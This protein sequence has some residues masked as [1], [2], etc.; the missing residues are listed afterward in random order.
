MRELGA[1]VAVLLV[2]VSGFAPFAVVGVAS[3]AGNTTIVVA[4]DG[5]GDHQTIQAGV[6]AATAG[7]TVEVQS[8]TYTEQVTVDTEI[9]LVAPNGATLDGTGISGGTV[10]IDVTPSLGSGLT[11]EG[12]TVTGYTDGVT[13]GGSAG[14]S[15]DDASEESISG[16]WTIRDLVSTG[17]AEDGLDI[18]AATGTGWTLRNVRATGNSDD[19]IEI[20]G[21]AS[22]TV[23]WRL[24]ESNASA[25]DGYGIRVSSTS[26]SWELLD[27]TTSDNRDT[28]LYVSGTSGAWTIGHHNASANSF[29]GIDIAGGGGGD[30]TIH[31]TTASDN[32]D[33]TLYR[34]DG[35][36]PSTEFATTTTDDVGYYSFDV[37]APPGEST[38]E[39]RL[40]FDDPTGEYAQAWYR[41]RHRWANA[42]AMRNAVGSH[43]RHNFQTLREAGMLL[44]VWVQ[45][46]S[47]C[48]D[49]TDA[50]SCTFP[51]REDTVT[52]DP[53]E[54]VAV[55][56]E[57]W[58]GDDRVYRDYD[59]DDPATRTTMFGAGREIAPGELR[60]KTETLTAPIVDGTYDYRANSTSDTRNGVVSNSTATYTIEVSGSVAQQARSPDGFSARISNPGS[61]EP[62]LLGGDDGVASTSGTTMQSL[63]LR[64]D[65]SNYTVNVTGNDS[66]PAGTAPLPLAPGG[67]AFGYFTVGHSIPD[68]AI[69]NV[70][71][72]LR[73]DRG[74]LSGAGIQPTDVTVYRYVD[75]VPTP[76]PTAVVEETSTAH[77]YETTSPGLS[78]FAVGTAD[79]MSPPTTEN[80]TPSLDRTTAGRT[81]TSVDTTGASSPGFTVVLTALALLVV[82]VRLSRRR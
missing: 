20:G 34:K 73:V 46:L 3:A 49:P 26:G 43:D 15:Y 40:H 59:V 44:D 78:V 72:R 32:S 38:V 52:V 69:A 21:F 51:D 47:T 11:I 80:A 50:D 79:L 9:T 14:E 22:G 65:G 6:D 82:A 5:T 57:L 76:L 61:G 23:A 81:G 62:V 4:A 10:G 27:S 60:S 18:G 35:P 74:D 17:N 16:G 36:G 68:T 8:G 29:N 24:L 31:N 1:L 63:L 30:W 67:T 19:G 42:T 58:N 41:D 54:T 37:P 55:H 33:V 71:F 70:T 7:D 39:T 64:T 77:V 75:G 13:V 28:G 53:N 66:A 48:Q 25:N 12:F 45:P 2:I 56:Y